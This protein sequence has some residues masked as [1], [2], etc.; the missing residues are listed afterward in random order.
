MKIDT[1]ADD[2]DDGK[3]NKKDSADFAQL[4][5]A[6]NDIKSQMRSTN[7]AELARLNASITSLLSS[8][9]PPE[10]L[11]KLKDLLSSITEKEERAEQVIR[12]TQ[13]E[14]SKAAEEARLLQEHI[15]FLEKEA[16]I[17]NERREQEL[18]QHFED[19][20]LIKDDAHKQNQDDIALLEQAAKDPNSL[21]AA[22]RAQLMGQYATDEEREAADKKEQEMKK[23]LEIHYAIK[24][25]NNETIAYK[26]SKIKA[27]DTI[28]NH[29][30]TYEPEKKKRHQEN[31]VLEQEIVN[32]RK[33]LV[34]LEP[35]DKDREQERQV[36][37]SLVN[38]GN[39]EL[40]VERLKDHYSDHI[41]K[42]DK[43]KQQDPNHQG[44][45]ELQSIV[46]K[47]GGHKKLGL[48]KPEYP[49]TEQ[50]IPSSKNI[51]SPSAADSQTKIIES[52]ATQTPQ[53]QTTAYRKSLEQ[54]VARQSNVKGESQKVLSEVASV[55][56]NNA[57]V[58]NSNEVPKP[59]SRFAQNAKKMAGRG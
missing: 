37:L 2:F 11:A 14:Q 59:K 18:K 31:V 38:S 19:Y 28:I 32:H 15:E 44:Y 34:S 55:A 43:E 45:N 49:I 46:M 24:K 23:C 30:A 50:Q 1:M 40:A 57:P 41:D 52:P 5:N 22:Q 58:Q 29:P 35:L 10:M 17:A 53:E 54:L 25:K 3:G 6:V 7:P 20:A 12:Y 42:Y 47:L 27:N 33:D 9:L 13:E 4:D 36:L 39:P 26:Q 21:T 51:K 16:H 8:D 48:P 56:T